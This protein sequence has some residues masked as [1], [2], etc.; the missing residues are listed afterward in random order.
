MIG[1][2][3]KPAVWRGV[4]LVITLLVALALRTHDLNWDQGRNLH[5]DERYVAVLA[6]L[7]QP[8]QNLREYFDSGASPLNPFNTDWGRAYVYGTLPL[9]LGRYFGEFLD[10]GCEPTRALLPRV[11]GALVFNEHARECQQGE[12]VGFGLLTL[13]GRLMSALADTLTV[14]VV[15][16]LGRRLLG[17]RVGLLAAVLA[18]FT[19][20]H[21]Q[22]AHYFTVDATANLFVVLAAYFAVGALQPP[23]TTPQT[24]ARAGNLALA[25]LMAGLALASKISTWP[26]GLLILLCAFLMLQRA[27]A[28]PWRATAAAAAGVVLA[29]VC[30]FGAFRI[31]Q[32]YAF[33]GNSAT[34][35]ALTAQSCFG[36]AEGALRAACQVGAG[37][38]SP[39]REIFTPSARWLQQL[40]LAQGFVNGTIDAPFGI[41]WAHR[42]PIVFPLVNIV[43]WGMGIPLAVASLAG[44]A[45]AARQI[46]RGRRWWALLPLVTWTVGYFLYQ[47]TQ[48]TKS[49][50]YLLPIYP[51][52]VILAAYGVW[53]LWRRWRHRGLRW[54]PVMGSVAGA[55]VWTFAFMHIY[56]G[57]IT[58]VEASRWMYVHVPTALT[59]QWEA[60]AAPVQLP[61]RDLTLMEGAP[62]Q[63]VPLPAEVSRAAHVGALRLTLNY[64]QGSALI[65]ARLLEMT[66]GETVGIARSAISADQPHLRFTSLKL[67]PQQGYFLELRALSGGPVIARTSVIA[68]EHWDDALPQRLEGRDPF[69]SYY[70]GLSSSS[71]GQ[72]QNYNDDTPQ[73]LLQML[74][75]LDEADYIAISSNR[76]YAS[77]PRLPWRYPMTTRYYRALFSGKLG[78]ELAA[79]FHR[80]PRLGP[81]IFN[82]QEMPQMLVRAHNTAGTPPGTFVPYPPAEEAYSVYDHPRVL[83]FRKTPRYT[84]ANAEAILGA[85]DFSVTRRQSP[86]DAANAPG[87]LLLDDLTLR[88]QQAGGTWSALFPAG[89][90]LNQS[91]L[92]AVL[93]WMALTHVLGIA[94]L[95]F[96]V[97]LARGTAIPDGRTDQA[98]RVP[99]GA[100]FLALSFT[101]GFALVAWTSWM[102]ASA[103]LAPFTPA[104]IWAVIAAVVIGGATVGHLNRERV[105][106]IL[107][108]D[109]WAMLAVE[110]TF[111]F[112]FAFF[113]LI[114]AGNPDLWHP[115]MGGE[116]PMDFAYFNSVLKAT[117]FPPQDPWFAG[118]YINYYYF[119]W[120]MVGA[121]VKA[122]GINPAVAYN[123]VIPT[124]FAMVAASAFALGGAFYAVVRGTSTGR[125]GALAAGACA[126]AFVA[127]LGNGDEIRVVAPAW[128]KLGGVEQGTP[129][130]IALITGIARWVG[131]APLPIYPNWPYWNP[132]RPAPEVWIAEFPLFTFLYADLHAHM[133]AMPLAYLALGMAL[134]FALGVINFASLAIGAGVVG[135]LWATN[136]WDYPTLLL[137]GIAGLWLGK[138]QQLSGDFNLHNAARAAL[139]AAPWAVA[140]FALGRAAIVPYLAHYGSAYNEIGLWEGERTQ[141]NTYVTIYGLFILSLVG[142]LATHYL[143][144]TASRWALLV[145]LIGGGV[146]ALAGVPTAMLSVPLIALSL[147][148]ALRPGAPQSGERLLWL[149]AGGAWVLTLFVE[150]FVLRGDIARMNTVFKFYIQAWLLLGVAAGVGLVRAVES[151]RALNAP[152]LPARLARAGFLLAVGVAVFLSALY[153]AFAIPAKINDRYTREAPTGLDGMAFMRFA[154]RVEVVNDTPY[155][156]PLRDDYE[157]MRWLQQH[158]AGSPTILEGTTGGALY[159]WGNRFSIYTGLPTVIGWQWHQRQQRAAVGDHVVYARDN[160]VALF[161][162]T[163]DVNIA[164]QLLRRYQPRYILL[165]ELERIYYGTQ[166]LAKFDAL[167][168]AGELRVAWRNARVV[169]YEVLHLSTTNTG[170]DESGYDQSFK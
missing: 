76:L 66:N 125:M 117:W 59:A 122:L 97:A 1:R 160:D 108:H 140:F 109:G 60:D 143:K 167:V 99:F 70:R 71:D 111:A 141:I 156:F 158:V 88:D 82:S 11:I 110:A 98:A 86:R 147:R 100:L 6:G 80:F 19:A 131:G 2:I 10:Q 95:M 135:L 53:A 121:P 62:A 15:Y 92:L 149:I 132:T 84:R 72:M 164:R 38:P 144:D 73:K 96:F 134:L 48:W 37:L 5:P 155:S 28:D 30:A 34:E 124:L 54:L 26:I 154:E 148:A 61:V 94:A 165:G 33:V 152:S 93:A 8:P 24:V 103:R 56:E 139:R 57:E 69:G 79:D 107:R 166:G 35:A 136:S 112:S 58:R 4:A 169:I 127:Y 55:A 151:L 21:I 18:T 14:L 115:Y 27:K 120:V 146:V 46:A 116:K 101:L 67:D 49:I 45:F 22:Q 31:A 145:A 90:P 114:R 133:M 128:E 87:G 50:R 105:F 20:L 118:G 142:W 168:E 17:W 42:M 75:W 25:G 91:E 130:P 85:A 161:Y 163:P 23:V 47:G 162:R 68:N 16:L 89:S 52:L 13:V 40:Q 170:A 104:T 81:F 77:I 39:L 83:I 126:M 36:L 41:Q 3:R 9:F 157:A 64:V 29:G 150:L 65:E 12:F 153:P 159:R 63:A 137:V 119:G 7:I 138:L 102:L 106:A 129:A 32:P 44:L 74:D 51:F 113:L 123:I 43:F 78:F